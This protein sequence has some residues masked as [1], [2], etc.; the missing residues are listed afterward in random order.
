M[1]HT[2]TLKLN[3]EVYTA[4]RREAEAAGIFPVDWAVRILERHRSA[5]LPRETA[6]VMREHQDAQELAELNAAYAEP[7][8]SE[9]PEAQNRMWENQKRQ[10]ADEA[11]PLKSDRE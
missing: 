5:R 3:D 1:S 10:M 9:E 2:L 11:S 8:T 6:S 4:I 7:P